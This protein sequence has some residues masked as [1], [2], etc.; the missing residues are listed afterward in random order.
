[1]EKFLANVTAGAGLV[2][3]AVCLLYIPYLYNATDKITNDLAVRMDQLFG[4]RL[5][6]RLGQKILAQLIA[7]QMEVSESLRR[8]GSGF[9][10]I[11]RERQAQGVCQCSGVNQ[12][13]PGAPGGPGAPGVPGEPGRRGS[14]GPPGA[15]G[16]VP[17]LP[18]TEDTSK[19]KVCP[20][21]PVGPPGSPGPA[22]PP[23]GRGV[24]GQPG[25][26]G[27]PGDAGAPGKFSFFQ[28]KFQPRA[29]ELQIGAN[30]RKKRKKTSVIRVSWSLRSSPDIQQGVP[31]E[32]E[33]TENK[34]EWDHQD[35]LVKLDHLEPVELMGEPGQAGVPGEP[36]VPAEKWVR[37]RECAGG[38]PGTPGRPGQPGSPGPD[39]LYCPC[40]RRGKAKLSKEE[41]R[42]KA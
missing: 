34:V 39:S 14:K 40:P 31:G 26:D 35:H 17:P 2:V 13:P 8:S 9:T 4:A 20:P 10:T 7:S 22:G 5:N 15:P 33:E 6:P 30:E 37:L 42:L 18:I 3:V 23:G 21:G 27:P 19:C 36:G 28:L 16:I 29:S 1:M 24:P 41:R 25:M 32:P 11:R 12:C 38:P